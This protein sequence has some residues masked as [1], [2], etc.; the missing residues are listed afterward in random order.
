MSISRTNRNLTVDFIDRFVNDVSESGKRVLLLLDDVV[1]DIRKNKGV[2]KALAKLVYNRRHITADGGDEANGVSVWLTTQ[3]HN[4]IP[5]M[6]RKVA[7]RLI[8][9]KLKNVKEIQ[10]IF[11]EYVVGLTKEQFI[12]ILK[13]VYKTPF[14][15]LYINMD[16][17]WDDMYYR[18]FNKLILGGV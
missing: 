9:F 11:D 7:T 5:H 3:A 14:D 16:E 10:S 18:N 13:F 15:F 8:A 6:I 2:D 4:R 1:N 17:S 12:T